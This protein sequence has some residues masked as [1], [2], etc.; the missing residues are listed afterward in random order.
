[1]SQQ[2]LLAPLPTRRDEDWRYADLPALA[3]LWP[4]RAQ[5]QRRLEGAEIILDDHITG[6][7]WHDER[8]EIDIA[9][10]G[11]L[12]GIVE[13]ASA[14]GGVT[15]S[16]YV[17]HL[18]DGACGTLS[19]VNRGGDYG[20]LALDI[21]LG[22]GASLTLNGAIVGGGSQTLEIITH[23]RHTGPGATSRQTVRAVLGGRATGTWLTQLAVAPA[24][25]QT[26]AV[27]SFK[28]LLLDRGAT[29]NTKPELEIF[30]DDVKCAHGASIGALDP[31]ALFYLAS[32]GLSPAQARVLLTRAF[33]ADVLEGLDAAATEAL[34]GEISALLET[35]A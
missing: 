18:A 17:I 20:R 29:A 6:D 9:A 26:D 25:Q 11:S 1:M 27:Q 31:A 5:R 14:P 19:L 28:A 4:N 13:Q 33:L 15:T 3:K 21:S 34:D 30:A 35:A 24:A 32:R 8:V 23:V 12:Q 2:A 22:A 10:G 16:H 7:G